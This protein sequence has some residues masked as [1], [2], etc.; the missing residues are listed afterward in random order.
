VTTSAPGDPLSLVGKTLAGHFLVQ[1]LAAEGHTSIVYRG[2]HVGPKRPVA[3]KCLKIKVELDAARADTFLK[4]LR[5]ET[6]AYAQ[7]SRNEAHFVRSI[8]TGMTA[9][10]NGNHLPYSVLEWLEGRT[11]AFDSKRRKDAGTAPRT[12]AEVADLLAPSARALA[13][14]HLH[15]LAHGDVSSRNIFLLNR[16][17]GGFSSKLL[18]FGVSKV[19]R[20]VSRELTPGGASAPI[21][22][23]PFWIPS[24]G[25]AAPEQFNRALGDVGPWTDVYAL[26]I[27]FLETL[28]DRP[29][30]TPVPQVST[31]G[32]NLPESV[33]QVLARALSE[34]PKDRWPGA[35]EFWAAFEDSLRVSAVRI[36]SRPPTPALGAQTLRLGAAVPPA[37]PAIPLG[38]K[39][40]RIGGAAPA[41][42]ATTSPRAA[43]IKPALLPAAATR[44]PPAAGMKLEASPAPPPLASPPVAAPTALPPMTEADNKPIVGT[45]VMFAS[46]IAS[47]VAPAKPPPPMPA[48]AKTQ[49][50]APVV[51][52]PPAPPPPPPLPM[53]LPPGEGVS[54]ATAEKSGPPSS[55]PSSGPTSG[56]SSVPPPP[57]PPGAV[58]EV[59]PGPLPP[60]PP[61]TAGPAS[62]NARSVSAAAPAA[63]AVVSM[64]SLPSVIVDAPDSLPQ[65]PHSQPRLHV[66]TGSE[67]VRL[68]NPPSGPISLGSSGVPSSNPISSDPNSP[69]VARPGVI[70]MPAGMQ[71]MHGGMHDGDMPSRRRLSYD[72]RRGKERKRLLV[73]VLVSFAV[74]FLVGAGFIYLHFARGRA[75]PTSLSAHSANN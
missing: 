69:L 7:A 48:V 44:I 46:P 57:P 62:E 34:T 18:D 52:A 14:V 5:E 12:L 50:I 26:A 22:D 8:G 61:S 66:A 33:E 9:T 10:G 21:E 42:T 35:G 73:V 27:V 39:T 28:L 67:T 29:I 55:K 68:H 25:Y 2:E 1:S 75:L 59:A 11:L 37:P 13:A 41:P 30:G 72:E 65:P 36:P 19:V 38:A 4:R 63:R 56:P 51:A 23:D 71:A 49:P 60:P 64:E 6:R 53:P 31:L 74:V 24:P 70:M 15:K 32:L 58:L 17:A 47:Q 40:I 20:D 3:L 16:A 43:P 45:P 54:V